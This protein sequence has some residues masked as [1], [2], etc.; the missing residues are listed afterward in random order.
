MSYP[1]F[2]FSPLVTRLF[3]RIEP[4]LPLLAFAS[5]VASFVL[6]DRQDGLARWIVLAVLL[7]WIW[8]LLEHG[9]RRL[10]TRLTGRSIPPVVG[11]LAVQW[12]HQESFFFV[13]P[14]FYFTTTWFSGQALFTGLLAL[15]GLLSVIDPFY[16]GTLTRHRWLL[17]LYH[18][19]AV[20]ALTLTAMPI[21]LE[22]TTGESYYAAMIALATVSVLTLPDFI[23]TR[24][25][26]H[27]SHWVALL[28]ALPLLIT[29]AWWGRYWVPPAGLWLER[30]AITMQIY[31][32]DK[33]P[34]K[35]LDVISHEDLHQK[36]LY[37]YAAIRAPLG[38]R[39]TIY[40]VWLRDG[41]VIDRIPLPIEGGREEGYRSWTHK[42]AFPEDA[43]GKWKVQMLTEKG[44]MIGVLR[45]T[46]E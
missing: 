41:E 36:G 23:K 39:E 32:A 35:G 1:A 42:L 17:M 45:F 10:F 26:W 15:A 19:L 7:G 43:R 37:A 24:P 40:H 25:E 5:G 46:V 31:S 16:F 27:T 13:L 38:L 28:V 2:S 22:M 30:S 8:L 20:F 6:V 9:L 11:R 21:M 14:F 44:Q 29:I 4:W 3:L 33:L 12:V 18:G 34:G